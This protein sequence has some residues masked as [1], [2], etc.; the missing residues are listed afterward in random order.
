MNNVMQG[1]Y[2]AHSHWND[3]PAFLKNS[4][5]ESVSKTFFFDCFSVLGFKENALAWTGFNTC[6]FVLTKY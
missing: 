4:T 6:D 3:E 1:K 5:F 2:D